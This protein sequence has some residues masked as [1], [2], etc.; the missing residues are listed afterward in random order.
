MPPHPT[1]SRTQRLETALQDVFSR[2]VIAPQYQLAVRAGMNAVAQF[3]FNQLATA[4]ADFGRIEGVHQESRSAS[5]C[6]FADGHLNELCPGHVQ[7]AF[8]HPAPFARS[9]QVFGYRP[10]GIPQAAAQGYAAD[11]L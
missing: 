9:H 1:L 10:S 11:L 3:L 8:A 2:I 5:F 6:R 4:R 7:N